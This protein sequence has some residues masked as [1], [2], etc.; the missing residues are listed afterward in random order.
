[1]DVFLSSKTA[2]WSAEQN[3][4]KDPKI[5]FSLRGAIKMQWSCSKTLKEKQKMFI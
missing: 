2:R 1:M 3:E 5:Q 4:N